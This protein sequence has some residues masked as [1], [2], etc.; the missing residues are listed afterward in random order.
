MDRVARLRSLGRRR[1]EVFECLGG[2]F[3]S[4]PS[5]FAL[6]ADTDIFA[7]FRAFIA[8]VT[9]LYASDTNPLTIS[10]L[11]A[12]RLLTGD[13]AAADV[14]L[15]HLPPDDFKLDHGA[16]RCLMVPLYT[17]SA[18]L[19]L[20]TDMKRTDRWLAYAHEPAALRA[21]LAEHR[22]KL[23]WVEVQGVYLPRRSERPAQPAQPAV[24]AHA[25]VRHIMT[26][27]REL[28][29]SN[30]DLIFADRV[31]AAVMGNPWNDDH[32]TVSVPLDPTFLH[33]IDWEDA[34]YVYECP[35]E[36]PRRRLEYRPSIW[37][38]LF[39]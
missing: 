36:A 37:R 19:P 13:L 22:E 29:H 24:G 35:I 31:P 5:Y 21:W 12:A 28:W 9:Q 17:L 16:G 8:H 20:P 27:E 32:P 34:D 3:R 7:A 11:A 39:G 2:N 33:N 4:Q 15:D 1:V 30:S 14:I 6:P 23:R 10:L 26:R 25:R 38:R 18:T